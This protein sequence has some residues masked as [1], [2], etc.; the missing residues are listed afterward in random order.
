[1]A[2][3]LATGGLFL[4]ALSFAAIMPGSA[5]T[6]VA[7]AAAVPGAAG[8]PLPT[9]STTSMSRLAGI[10]NVAQAQH[11]QPSGQHAPGATPPQANFLPAVPAVAVAAPVLTV[12][13]TVDAHEAGAAP[14]GTCSAAAPAV[15]GSC[16]LRAAIETANASNGAF[17]IDLPA[18]SYP[19]SLGQ[20]VITDTVGVSIV[21]A[22][23]QTTTIDGSGQADRVLQLSGFGVQAQLS[24]L[25]ITGGTAPTPAN[26]SGVDPGWGGGISVYTTSGSLILDSVTVSNNT[27]SNGGGGIDSFGRLWLTNSTVAG[28]LVTNSNDAWSGGGGI[29][30]EV[31]GSANLTGTAVTGNTIAGTGT[32]AVTL[33]SGGGVVTFGTL[34]VSGGSLDHNTVNIPSGASPS[35]TSEGDGGAM[36]V[37][38]PTT[39][40]GA[41]V[42]DNSLVPMAGSTNTT[43]FGG[44]VDAVAG[45]STVAGSWFTSNTATSDS[46][47]AGGGIAV[48]SGLPGITGTQIEGNS[49][50]VTNGSFT[51]GYL[52]LGS[53]AGGGGVAAVQNGSV[54][55]ASSN[56]SNNFVQA[57]T[58]ETAPTGATLEAGGGGLLVLS[59]T[60][61]I[62][63]TTI[64]GN[65]AGSTGATMTEGDGGGVLALNSSVGGLIIQRSQ[66]TFN[67]AYSGLGGGLISVDTGSTT[68]QSDTI[69]GN[70]ATAAPGPFSNASGSGGG[71][72]GSGTT[73]ITCTTLDGNSAD[74][75][76][77]GL[78]EESGGL[79]TGDTISYNSAGSGGGLYAAPFAAVSPPTQILNSTF[80]GNSSTG[81]GGAIVAN[82]AAIDLNYSTVTENRAP[83]GPGIYVAAGSTSSPDSSVNV[84]GSIVA[85]SFLGAADCASA[86]YGS[87][88][89]SSGYNLLGSSCTNDPAPTD[90]V[91]VDPMLGMLLPNGGPTETVALLPG[92]PALNAGGGPNCPSTDQRGEPRPQGR[93]CDI[94]AFESATNGY[95]LV[96]SDGGIFTFGDAGFFG[97]EGGQ[98]LNKPV[99][100][101]ASSPDG[102]GYWLV[103]SDGGIFT[104]G[105]AEFHGSEGSHHLNQPI[106]GMAATPS[107]RGYW[108]VAADGGIFT[109]G[110]AQFFG[111]MGGHGLTAPIVSMAATPDGGGYWLTAANGS[112]FTFGDA[113]TYG[114]ASGQ[115]LNAPIVSMAA[116]PDGHGYWLVASD[117]TVFNFGD[118]GNLGSIFQ[119]LNAPIT[120]IAT[121]TD[122]DGYWLFATDGGVFSF[123]DALFE[124]SMGGQHLNKPVVGGATPG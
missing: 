41:N 90:L 115:V 104:F 33:V 124:G 55:M 105:D 63:S 31:T 96:A 100:G 46:V 119:P 93:A 5:G 36:T 8:A 42:W 81:P 95:W 3:A 101:M 52:G 7:E 4:G 38:G 84:T 65:G 48:Q 17:T 68:L 39:L 103:A 1:V 15:E 72:F 86:F 66:L 18:G 61:V 109:F 122:G 91:G 49:A 73:S 45:L 111:S 28:N 120:G 47:T 79:L 19:L 6:A 87:V 75:V 107:G 117:G 102:Q 89:N 99:V 97:S 44:G 58:T 94:G 76:G 113:G 110:D 98:P 67:T 35:S 60:S 27:A 12:D 78:V 9:P 112:V 50:T 64:S 85:G 13:T 22:E 114:D 69:T 74:L 16:T 88:V 70:T 20:L 11:A 29:D 121:T 56:I 51:G 25:T 71:V 62:N 77:G 2:T 53:L 108:L 116:T 106:V 34:A 54:A 43:A 24:N 37:D 82:A 30:N 83:S 14:P 123:G 21:G 80:V 118:A 26:T 32:P 40:T 10:N 92:S 57:S 59:G 23:Q